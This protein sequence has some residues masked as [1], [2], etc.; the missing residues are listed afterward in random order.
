MNPTYTPSKSVA[1]TI[2]KLAT[3]TVVVDAATIEAAKAARA[4]AAQKAAVEQAKRELAEIESVRESAVNDLREYR[5]YAKEKETIL[6]KLIEAENAY[7]KTGD[8]AA[9]NKARREARGY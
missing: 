3:A 6:G 2:E 5:K 4:E 7:N 9:W 8:I 1:A